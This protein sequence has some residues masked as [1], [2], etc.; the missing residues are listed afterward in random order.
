MNAK[1]MML[2][3]CIICS[4]LLFACNKCEE[5]TDRPKIVGRTDIPVLFPYDLSNKI[6]FLKNKKD[7]ISFYN[8]GIQTSYNYTNT[9]AECPVKIPLEQKSMQLLDS[10]GGNSIGLYY[11]VNS[12]F[13]QDFSIVVNNTIVAN[14]STMSFAPTRPV[15][16]TTILGKYY[17][18][19][20]VWTINFQ[21]SVVFK[22]VNYGVLKYTSNG[23]LFELI[24]E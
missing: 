23:D 15:L 13:S 19:I 4:L 24:P 16:H 22:T 12:A 9:Q 10:N 20:S 2:E 7:T 11:Y 18:T 5:T 3:Y 1:L 17:D 6:K 8:L 14:S 21:D